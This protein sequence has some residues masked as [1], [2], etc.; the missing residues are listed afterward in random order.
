VGFLPCCTRG[1]QLLGF[2]QAFHSAC[3][4]ATSNG[5]PSAEGEAPPLYTANLFG[6]SNIGNTILVLNQMGR[7]LGITGR[8]IGHSVNLF[9]GLPQVVGSGDNP[10]STIVTCLLSADLASRPCVT[11]FL[12]SLQG[13]G[14]N[15]D[16]LQA[17]LADLVFGL[18]PDLNV[19]GSPALGK[20]SFCQCWTQAQSS[21]AALEGNGLGFS[22]LGLPPG[23]ELPGLSGMLNARC[24]EVVGTLRSKVAYSVLSSFS[25]LP[26]STTATSGSSPQGGIAAMSILS[27]AKSG[28]HADIPT[29]DS[30]AVQT[31]M[32]ALGF[33]DGKVRRNPLAALAEFNKRQQHQES[34]RR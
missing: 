22:I 34:R 1:F 27:P 25:T 5:D 6:L 7:C 26:A 24:N 10:R 21:L 33:A 3:T 29:Q 14:Q 23:T 30:P 12:A 32:K 15:P 9:A 18:Q 28:Q 2:Y 8:T 4:K 13:I 19:F 31:I 16:S 20:P 17:I 11:A